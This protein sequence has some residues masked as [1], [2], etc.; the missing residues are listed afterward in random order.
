MTREVLTTFHPGI[1]PVPYSGLRL[2]ESWLRREQR[3]TN[4]RLSMHR[5]WM[6]EHERQGKIPYRY[7]SCIARAMFSD[8]QIFE[9][10][11]CRQKYYGPWQ[12]RKYTK[13]PNGCWTRF[14][15]REGYS[16]RG[17]HYRSICCPPHPSLLG[18]RETY[19]CKS[20]GIYR[21][22]AEPPQLT[23]W[24]DKDIDNLC[25]FCRKK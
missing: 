21:R 11:A 15:D 14:E 10:T 2:A 8:E 4:A 9:C 12:L 24:T 5:V 13:C 16:R 1:L 20:C 19:D 3:V 6:R 22:S 25:I 17:G 18:K 23:W 7:L